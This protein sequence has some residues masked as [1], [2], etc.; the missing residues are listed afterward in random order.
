MH[1]AAGLAATV[2]PAAQEAVLLVQNLGPG[3][4]F[5]DRDPAVTAATGLKLTV[6]QTAEFLRSAGN[7][8]GEVWVIADQAATDVRVLPI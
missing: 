2:I 5:V 8:G 4:L 7:G 3:N 6:G 1:I